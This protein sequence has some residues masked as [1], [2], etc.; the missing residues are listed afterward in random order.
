MAVVSRRT[1]QETLEEMLS[2]PKPAQYRL[3]AEFIIND[4]LVK[5]RK[6]LSVHEVR[7]F[8]TSYTDKIEVEIVMVLGDYED[9]IFPNRNNLIMTITETPI[10]EIVAKVDPKRD[11]VV[12]TYRAT[13]IGIKNEQLTSVPSIDSQQSLKTY[14]LQLVELG[15]DELRLMTVG[16]IFS[17]ERTIDVIKGLLGIY[18]SGLNLPEQHR[19]KGVEE[20]APN[21]T[22]PKKN[23][24]VP[25]GTAL[26]DVPGYIQKYA[27]GVYNYGLGFYLHKRVWYIY[28][29][30]NT[31]QYETSR[32]RLDILVIPQ[33]RIEGTSR[34]WMLKSQTLYVATNGDRDM[35][36]V[37]DQ[38]FLNKGN[39][40]RYSLASQTF[41]AW[42]EV[43]GNR[44]VTDPSKTSAQ[45]IVAGRE[46]KKNAVPFGPRRL[47]DNV[48]FETSEITKRE[49]RY[50]QFAWNN[51][52]PRLL[53]PGMPVKVRYENPS[54]IEEVYGVLIK[55]ES[56][57]TLDTPGDTAER[58][59]ENV[60]LTVF[61]K[62]R[63][64]APS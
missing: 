31:D 17:Q 16:G 58:H 64:H 60:V 22:E 54:G 6:L 53:Y 36:D 24:I 33:N 14:K 63:D 2:S 12:R 41:N 37:V 46:S 59:R 26:F 23:V 30:Y 44:A 7:D 8:D 10:F 9:K 34:S 18:S 5:P 13:I 19:I 57:A 55:A 39:G 62:P 15:I 51:A 48:A 20:R 45:Y 32:F 49:G 52:S 28:P 25:Q 40:V 29:L 47:T 4:K 50:F 38:L 43:K 42:A 61:I 21:V 3:D 1:Y 56:F 35:I 11:I 27:G